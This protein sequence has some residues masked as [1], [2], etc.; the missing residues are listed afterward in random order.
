MAEAGVKKLQGQIS[1]HIIPLE[2]LKRHGDLMERAAR[3]GFN[4][5][6]ANNGINLFRYDHIGGHPIYNN[7]IFEELER[8]GDF[9]KKYNMSDGDIA[10]KIQEASNKMRKAI[11][12]GTFGPL[13]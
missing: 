12:D 13:G 3:G 2:S 5:N 1:H 6:G 11:E 9:A 4:I 8:I 10:R 7:E